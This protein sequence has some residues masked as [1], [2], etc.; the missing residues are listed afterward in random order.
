MRSAGASVPLWS[1]PNPARTF[2]PSPT[3]SWTFDTG[4]EPAKI[5]KI[6]SGM[7]Y[8]RT[9]STVHALSAFGDE[10][11]RYDAEPEQLTKPRE[12]GVFPTYDTAYIQDGGT[13]SALSRTDGSERWRYEG[14]Q[15]PTVE[16][17][18]ARDAIVQDDG[19]VALARTD[20]SER[21]RFNTSGGVW[22]SPYYD[23]NRLYVG[24]IHGRLYA[25]SAETGTVDWKTEFPAPSNIYPIEGAADALF[26][27]NSND[28]VLHVFS[29]RDGAKRWEYETDDDDSF[30]FPGTIYGD[31]V[32]LVDGRFVRT[33]SATEGKERWR[34]DIGTNPNWRPHVVGDT[35]FISKSGSVTALSTRDGN[36]RWQFSV[37]SEKTPFVAGVGDDRV[38]VHSRKGATYSLSPTDGE[39]HWRFEHPTG[40]TWLPRMADGTVFLSTA[41]GTVYALSDPDSTPVYDA[42]RTV[43]S[44]V[45]LLTGGL[46][47]GAIF[48][49]AYRRYRKHDRNCG[50]EPETGD[51]PTWNGYELHDRIDDETHLARTSD[52]ET[53][54]LRRFNDPPESFETDAQAW[55]ELDFDGVQRVHDWGTDPEPWL[56]L[57]HVD[58]R[59]LAESEDPRDRSE[60]VEIV[61]SVA[62]TLHR[63]RR[64]GV[65]HENPRPEYI[66]LGDERV[67]VTGWWHAESERSTEDDVYDL[68]LLAVELLTGD[69]TVEATESIESASGDLGD[70]LRTATA[71]NPSDRYDSALAFHGMLRWAA[72]HGE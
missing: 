10:Q 17:V 46:L 57:E 7:L 43:T 3:T 6:V 63:A 55:N 49:G 50:G 31:T 71:S 54:L 1:L 58:G 45:G 29:T 23:G 38:I 65:V 13:V 52:G 60:A 32:Y 48:A 11:W 35:V 12:L 67:V 2:A 37:D 44:P 22:R 14:G 21:W 53:V 34:V 36:R 51:V 62:E 18:T 28:G 59:P 56:A 42:V 33:L 9:D 30:S 20:G 16:L 8:A 68:G 47:G 15:F 40:L 24:T 66:L 4:D 39:V 69:R 41:D 19:I 26:V 70:V 61:S 25:L 64:R 27:W 72:F 5:S